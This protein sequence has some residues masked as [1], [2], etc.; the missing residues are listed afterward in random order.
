MGS[1]KVDRKRKKKGNFSGGRD[2]AESSRQAETRFK[3]RSCSKSFTYQ[4]II[5]KNTTYKSP[6]QKKFRKQK[7]LSSS[8]SCSDSSEEYGGVT[9]KKLCFSSSSSD[10]YGVVWKKRF[11]DQK[12][13]SRKR[14][15][16]RRK[17][18]NEDIF[19][20]D[21]DY[22]MYLKLLNGDKEKDKDDGEYENDAIVADGNSDD[23]EDGEEN[24]VIHVDTDGDMLDM[25]GNGTGVGNELTPDDSNGGDVE[26]NENIQVDVGMTVVSGDGIDVGD[27][28]DPEYKMFCENLRED[29]EIY[30]LEMERE[31]GGFEPSVPSSCTKGKSMT[32]NNF[33]PLLDECK[34]ELTSTADEGYCEFLKII[35]VIDG[36]L[37]M[38]T[39]DIIPPTGKHKVTSSVPE[40]SPKDG[41]P[42]S[43]NQQCEEES[44][45]TISDPGKVMKDGLCY[46]KDAAEEPHKPQKSCDSQLL[47]NSK[48]DGDDLGTDCSRSEYKKRLEECINMPYD[49]KEFADKWELAS[50][51]KECERVS[52]TGGHSVSYATEKTSRSYLDL[53]PDLAELVDH[54]LAR[55]DGCR[56]LLLLRCLFFYTEHK[57]DEGAF[58]PWKDPSFEKMLLD[59][60]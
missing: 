12:D 7:Q 18:R 29:G 45:G 39:N 54:A 33:H 48:T 43:K 47:P 10:D 42:C 55:L 24:E 27:E 19:V 56:A 40:K 11:H 49:E 15:H 30:I 23:D 8:S 58:I 36:S 51:R 32:V 59:P 50:R 60:V 46:C 26:E 57:A 4:N 6:S 41:F 21:C 31:K 1:V 20:G 44:R 38:R 52:E 9:R 2:F 25:S 5:Y 13:S 16:K 14:V 53:H 37:I 17:V 34:Q 22:L 3:Y 28:L 35:G